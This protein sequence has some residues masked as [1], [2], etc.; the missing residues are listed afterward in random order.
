M[1]KN[2]VLLIMLFIAIEITAQS[3]S[4]F[5]NS[6]TIFY[7]FEN[8]FIVVCP[9][10][11]ADGFSVSQSENSKYFVNKIYYLQT[12]NLMAQYEMYDKD[13]TNAYGN[14]KA[15]LPIKNG[16][17]EEWYISGEKRISCFYTE[18]SLMENLKF[19]IKMEI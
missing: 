13:Y 1:K 11:K 3:D 7:K 18:D 4:D 5:L 10:I 2:I 12:E 16:K 6:D 17:Y 15:T 19:S 9:R 8:G 14:V